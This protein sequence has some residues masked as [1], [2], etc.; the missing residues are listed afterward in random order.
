MPE[1]T[2][3]GPGKGIPKL[4]TLHK[5]TPENPATAP[6]IELNKEYLRI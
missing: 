5:R 1:K 3:I 4:K 6:K 2:T